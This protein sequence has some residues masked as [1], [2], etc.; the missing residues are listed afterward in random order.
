MGRLT[1]GATYIYENADGDIY[2]REIGKSERILIGT[3]QHGTR[4][5]LRE[6]QLWHD[7]LAAAKTNPALQEALDR[8]I[9]IYELSKQNG[10]T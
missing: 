9:I 6:Q 10:Q 3:D 7:I 1:P 5:R 4:A 8:A 2:A